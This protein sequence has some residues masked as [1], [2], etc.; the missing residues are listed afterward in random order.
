MIRRKPS[1]N[2][3][4][5]QDDKILVLE[6]EQPTKPLFPSLPGGQIDP[7]E[8]PLDAA[9]RELLEETGY[10]SDELILFEEFFGSPKFL[11]HETTFIAKNI[12]KKCEQNLDSGE[13]ISVKFVDFDEFLELCREPSFAVSI[14][15]KLMMYEAL[16]DENKKE[17]F[18]KRIFE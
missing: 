6:Q 13:K 14:G 4:A 12:S 7:G 9:K 15:L 1:T 10:A 16:L 18:K 11:F 8:N 17:E 3:I 5:V 2:V